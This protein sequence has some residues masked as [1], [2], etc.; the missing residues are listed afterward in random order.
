MIRVSVPGKVILFGEHSVVY[1]H[2]AVAIAIR[3][4]T[5]MDTSAAKEGRTLVNREA[6][7]L[8]RELHGARVGLIISCHTPEEVAS[9]IDET[10]SLTTPSAPATPTEEPTGAQPKSFP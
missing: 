7:A 3:V 8:M 4:R 1:G 5:E 2:P 9:F 6:I 10:V